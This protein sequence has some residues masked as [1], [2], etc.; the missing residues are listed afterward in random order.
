[1]LYLVSFGRSR[2]EQT[3]DLCGVIPITILGQPSPNPSGGGQPDTEITSGGPGLQHGNCYGITM[4]IHNDDGTFYMQQKIGHLVLRRNYFLPGD[5]KLPRPFRPPLIALPRPFKPPPTTLLTFVRTFD[6]VLPAFDILPAV[7]PPA[8]DIL[9]AVA[10]PAFD[11]LPAVAPPAFDIL[12]AVAPPAFD[13]LPAVAPPAFDI[14]PAVA[15]PAFDILFVPVLF[16]ICVTVNSIT[17]THYLNTICFTNI[18]NLFLA[19]EIWT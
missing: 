1:M 17:V 14:L 5:I 8:F 19:I 15:P 7:A 6:D 10:P 11:I 3:G 13:I 18:S 12:P 16:I 2:S 9:P 4:G